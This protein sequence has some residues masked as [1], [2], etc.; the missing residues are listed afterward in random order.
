MTDCSLV[1]AERLAKG[2]TNTTSLSFIQ[3]YVAAAWYGLQIGA[4]QSFS[5]V[6]M[7][8]LVPPGSEAEFFSLYEVTDKGSSWMGPLIV[9]AIYDKTGNFRDAFWFLLAATLLPIP[10]IWFVNMN[11]GREAAKSFKL[12]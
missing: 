6:L 5:R 12:E 11:R 3:L 10:I 4:I 1:P 2:K 9:A 8:E 7:A